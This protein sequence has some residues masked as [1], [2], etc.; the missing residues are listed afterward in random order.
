MQIHTTRGVRTTAIVA[1]TG[2]VL[3]SAGFGAVYAY[4]VGIHHGIVLAGLTV[5]FAVALELIKP[6]AIHSAFVAWSSWRTWHHA[7]ALSVLGFV[8]VCYSLTAELALTA[9]SRGD[10]TAKREQASG[11][12]VRAKEAHQRAKQE[13]ASLKPSRSVGELTALVDSA[14]PRCRVYVSSGRRQTVCSKP[15]SLV[16]ELGRAKRRAELEAVLATAEDTLAH[17]PAVKSSDPGATALATYLGIMG[18]GV[19]VETLG[20]WLILVPVLALELG[21]ALAMVLVAVC[22]PARVEPLLVHPEPHT[23]TIVTPLLPVPTTHRQAV[24]KLIENHL[25]NHGGTI[26]ANE[27]SLA[28]QLGTTKP[29]LRRAIQAMA[30]TGVVALA[31][32]KQGTQLTLLA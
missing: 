26:R 23:G 1:S 11:A 29:T 15:A 3:A 25:R 14:R 28:R 24:A 8:A 6:L 22:S 30:G 31:A 18:F 32:S 27:R 9:S 7:F 21:S 20:Q 4:Q 19:A 2:L 16:A 17:T 12:S 5:L 13:L 10:L